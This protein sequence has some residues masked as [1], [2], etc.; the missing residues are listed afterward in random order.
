[1]GGMCKDSAA[2]EISLEALG[3]LQA[4]LHHDYDEAQLRANYMVRCAL[5][6]DC[7]KVAD[8]AE[9]IEALLARGCPNAM[10]LRIALR[11]LTTSVDGMRT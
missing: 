8:A 11:F 6:H 10:E 5:Q 9:K 7:L 3:L 2:Q 1:M 4:L